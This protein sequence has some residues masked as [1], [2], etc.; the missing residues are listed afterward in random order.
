MTSQ[1]YCCDDFN[2]F[3]S[4]PMTSGTFNT[5]DNEDTSLLPL[6]G[7][8][9]VVQNGITDFDFT[10]FWESVKPLVNQSVVASSADGLASDGVMDANSSNAGGEI[11]RVK[12]ADEVHALFSGCVMIMI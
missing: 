9:P 6:P 1:C 4:D 8:N 10:Q 12:L 3:F 7:S 5:T 11:D 2:Q